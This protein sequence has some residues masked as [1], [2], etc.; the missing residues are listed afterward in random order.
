[1][2]KIEIYNRKKEKQKYEL[3]SDKIEQIGEKHLCFSEIGKDFILETIESSDYLLVHTFNSH[4]RG[5][6]FLS[7]Y[8][9]PKKYLYID[10]ICNT[11]FHS[12]KTRSTKKMI[13]FS[14]KNILEKII[15]FGKKIKVKYIELSAIKNVINYYYN[16]GFRFKNDNIVDKNLLTRLR[17]AQINKNEK[18]EKKILN[19][20]IGKYFSGFYN[21]KIQQEYGMESENKKSIATTDGMPMIYDYSEK[22]GQSICKGKSIK[23][24]NRCKKYKEC[25]IT[26]G[27]KRNFC[28]TKKNKTKKINK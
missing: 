23:N 20:M 3:Y 21:E 2:S 6:A 19:K 11:R 13:K 12:M 17:E 15:E 5:F 8:N 18:E 26:R 10:L 16:I 4:I 9:Y 7:Y 28:R 27:T 1:M 24:P 14:G 22:K 25:I